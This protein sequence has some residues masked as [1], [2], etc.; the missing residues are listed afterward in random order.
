M[1][2]KVRKVIAILFVL[3]ALGSVSCI[4][5]NSV[6]YAQINQSYSFTDDGSNISNL[7]QAIKDNWIIETIG[8]FVYTMASLIESNVSKIFLNLTGVNTFPWADKILFNAVPLLDINFINS[9]YGSLFKNEAGVSTAVANVLNSTYYTVFTLSVAFLGVCV[10]IMALRLVFA[11]IASEKARYKKAI[12]Q[13]LMA[14]IML[15]L[16]HYLISFIFFIN[17]QMV[18]IASGLLESSIDKIDAQKVKLNTLTEDDKLEIIVQL[19]NQINN[20]RSWGVLLAFTAPGKTAVT[21]ATSIY[22]TVYNLYK[23]QNGNELEQDISKLRDSKYLDYAY[24]LI[25]DRYYVKKE[26]SSVYSKGDEFIEKLI[27]ITK[28]LVW[29]F[30]GQ[31]V[32]NYLKDVSFLKYM[33][34]AGINTV[35]DA[36]SCIDTYVDENRGKKDYLKS[37]LFEVW[38]K[39]HFEYGTVSGKDLFTGIGQFF[40]ESA[41]IYKT[42]KGGNIVGWKAGKNN[43]IATV[44]YAIFVVQSILFFMAYLKRFFY[45]TILALFAP[46][47]VVFDFFTKTMA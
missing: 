1:Y 47:V 45:V 4:T 27:D 29:D 30:D 18:E 17:E 14:L 33:D 2:K 19:I 39:K 15:F 25:V 6:V 26:L 35:T 38:E 3:L 31:E 5:S 13:W 40:R 7:D 46:L 22:S 36:K 41:W 32:A 9:S 20:D 42:D 21:S 37:I 12:T 43:I 34:D 28:N 10:G 11:S 44:L 8:S 16:S 23:N 24:Y